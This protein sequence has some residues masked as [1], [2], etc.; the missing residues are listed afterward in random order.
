MVSFDGAARGNPGP[1]AYG[2]CLWWGTW[3][4][5]GFDARGLILQEGRT[6]GKTTNNVAEAWGLSRAVK[7]VS[8]W[9]ISTSWKLAETLEHSDR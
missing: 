5:R 1:A 7:E 8:A 2:V 9:H 3:H 6:L 4:G